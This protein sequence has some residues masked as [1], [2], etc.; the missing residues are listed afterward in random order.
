MTAMFST[1]IHEMM[2]VR[3]MEERF[4]SKEYIKNL[5]EELINDFIKAGKAT[6]PCAVGTNR[7]KALMNK[8]K[9]ILPHGIGVGSGFVID[10]L[11]NTS[12]QCDLIIYE[13]EFALKFIINENDTYAYYNCESVIAV[14]EI[15]SDASIADVEDSFRK[16]KKI[17]ELIRYKE[18]DNSFRSYLS[19]L[20]VWGTDSEKYEPTKKSTDQIFTFVLCKSL[21][22]PLS[23]IANKAKEIFETK[24]KYFNIIFPIEGKPII[25]LEES[26]KCL[27]QSALDATALCE[28]S[29]NDIGFNY[30]ITRL[31]YQI[32]HGRSV[33]LN[34]QR[35]MQ[36]KNSFSVS[37]LT[38]IL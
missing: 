31:L 3:T 27:V 4:D 17:R 14:G 32:E 22:T 9:S 28:L 34:T 24:D 2:M 13:E 29:D 12:S 7:E 10:S 37:T 16:L 1:I 5:G 8:L 25:Y 23:S 21:K 35:Y 18:D 11:G 36:S 26:N 19:K 20:A 6:H 33:P 38:S 15:K 30:F